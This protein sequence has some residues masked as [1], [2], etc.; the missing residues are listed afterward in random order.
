MTIQKDQAEQSM[1][2]A[3]DI[4]ENCEPSQAKKRKSRSFSVARAPLS[5]KKKAREPGSP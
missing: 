5:S 1:E 4:A 2:N 3:S